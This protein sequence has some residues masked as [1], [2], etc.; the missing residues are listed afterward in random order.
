MNCLSPR[1]LFY[2]FFL[3]FVSQITKSGAALKIEEYVPEIIP[4]RSV[5]MNHR[6]VSPPNNSNADNVNNTVSEVDNDLAK[7]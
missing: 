1:H 4:I 7:V 2:L 6:I 5:I 3:S